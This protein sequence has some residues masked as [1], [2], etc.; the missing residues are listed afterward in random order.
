MKYIF[1]P[2]NSRRLGRSLGI[3]FYLQKTCNLNCVYCEVGPSKH[4]FK[5]RKE[6]TPTLEIIQEIKEFCFDKDRIEG[7]D[8]VTITGSGEPTLHSG[9]GA[10]LTNIK[11][12]TAKPVTVITNATLLNRKDVQEELLPADT[13]IPS[14]DSAL[15][16]SFNQIDRPIRDIT[17][18]QIIK[19]ITSFSKLFQGTIWLEVLF[20]KNINDSAD[21]INAIIKAAAEMSL[22]KIQLNTVFRPPAIA[23]AQPVEADFLIQVGKIIEKELSIPVDV[24]LPSTEI[25][26]PAAE[27]VSFSTAE[28]K[29]S[30]S[31]DRILEMIKRRPCTAS[32]INRTFQHGSPEKIAQLLKP[33]IQS[34]RVQTLC[35]E[36]TIFYQLVS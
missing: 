3:D 12:Q 2:V 27:K 34:G 10:I 6:Y 4:L 21:D 20:A 1:G 15:I 8:A 16:K 25:E 31:I 11:K 9:L 24:P 7:I 13:V 14:L 23:T 26:N 32:D 5:A 22:D 17:P 29:D 28:E 18:D 30:E 33:L 36:N 19:G 35:H